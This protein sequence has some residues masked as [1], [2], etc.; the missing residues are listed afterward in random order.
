MEWLR[1]GL[2]EEL[3]ER[4]RAAYDVALPIAEV[5]SQ[6]VAQGFLTEKQ[7]GLELYRFPATM[8][9]D[10]DAQTAHAVLMERAERE[11]LDNE[12]ID[13]EDVKQR[14][15]ELVAEA[16]MP[17]R[18]LYSRLRTDSGLNCFTPDLT[19][20]RDAGGLRARAGRVG[21]N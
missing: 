14:L 5:E 2:P 19:T 6:L 9:R 13:L 17:P 12:A 10:A 15:E 11:F 18:A 3:K 16:K 8:L 1:S 7:H 4:M 21:R 20:N